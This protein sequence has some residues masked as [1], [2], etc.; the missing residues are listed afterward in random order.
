MCQC[1]GEWAASQ[2]AEA[3]L[4]VRPLAGQQ[5]SGP[6]GCSL[7][8]VWGRGLAGLKVSWPVGGQ[9]LSGPAGQQVGG[10]PVGQ[11]A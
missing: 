5:P 1:A 3:Q 8:V 2:Q 10:S 9:Q 4:A 7:V 11:R 6:V